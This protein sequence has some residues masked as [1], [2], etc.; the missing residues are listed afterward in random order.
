MKPKTEIV[1]Q[2]DSRSIT[3][4]RMNWLLARIKTVAEDIVAGLK[5]DRA[6]KVEPEAKRVPSGKMM[7]CTHCGTEQYMLGV[8]TSAGVSAPFCR[9][10]GLGD[11]FEDMK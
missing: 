2:A 3:I 6:A 7:V 11:K 1:Y 9:W 4:S 10:C 5:R 8:P